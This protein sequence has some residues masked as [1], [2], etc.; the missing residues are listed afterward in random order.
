MKLSIVIPVF[1][2]KDTFLSL[3]DR[4]RQTPFDKEIILVEDCSTDGTRDILKKLAEEDTSLKMCFFM[5]RHGKRRSPCN[6]F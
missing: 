6:R 2:E 1:N 3:L 4:V 5:K